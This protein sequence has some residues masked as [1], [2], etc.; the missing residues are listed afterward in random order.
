MSLGSQLVKGSLLIVACGAIG[1]TMSNYSHASRNYQSDQAMLS[2]V[3]AQYRT[4]N[5]KKPTVKTVTTIHQKAMTKANQYLKLQNQVHD[6]TDRAKQVKLIDK[7]DKLTSGDLVPNGP[8]VYPEIKNW[9]AVVDYGGQTSNGKVT[10]A[11]RWYD[12]KNQ[13]MRVD[14][15]YYLPQS[16]TLAGF[17]YY[18]TNAGEASIKANVNQVGGQ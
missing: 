2:Q 14:T 15:F 17:S 18:I 4:E 7:M 11:Y 10:M 5:H 1:V 3:K 16:Q 8:L 6:Q 9:H 12:D 13:L